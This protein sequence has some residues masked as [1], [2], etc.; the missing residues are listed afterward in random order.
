MAGKRVDA[1]KLQALI[2]QIETKKTDLSA[3]YATLADAQK[4]V[5]RLVIELENARKAFNTQITTY[6]A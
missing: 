3:A 5:D 6:L 2:D 1:V 4:Q